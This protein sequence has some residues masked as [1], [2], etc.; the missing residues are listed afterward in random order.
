MGIFQVPVTFEQNKFGQKKFTQ[1]LTPYKGT[2]VPN[3]KVFEEVGCNRC[4]I[5]HGITLF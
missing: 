5:L 1:W 4:L 3:L 2:S